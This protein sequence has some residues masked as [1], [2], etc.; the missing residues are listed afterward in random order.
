[1]RKY[2]L[3]RRRLIK[4]ETE[5]WE[6]MVEEYRELEREMCEKK[7]APTLPNVKALFLG[8]FEPLRD[9]IEKEQKM[10]RTKKHKAAFALHIDLLPADKMAEGY[11]QVVQAAIQI[12]VAIEQ[13][14]RIHSF[15]EKTKNSQSK[16]IVA[17]TEDGLHKEKQILRKRV[18]S[19][20]RKRKLKEAQKLLQKEEFKPWGRDTQAK[21]IVKN[22]GIIECDPLILMGLDKTAKH[23]LIPYVPMLKFLLVRLVIGKQQ[24]AVKNVPVKQMQKV[25]EALDMLGNTKWRVNRRVFSV[26]ESIWAR[27]GN[28]AGLVDCEDVPIPEKPSSED[29]TEIQERKWS[30]RKAKKINLERHSQRR[31]TEL[32]LSVVLRSFSHDGR[33]AFVNNHLDDIFDSADNPVNRNQWWLTDPFQFLAACINLSEALR[34]SSP[35]TVVS[36]LLIHQ[37]GWCNGLQHYTALG[38]DSME[39]AAVHLTAGDKPA[40]FY[41]EIAVRV[42]DIM[43]RDS[44]KDPATNPHALLVFQVDR[45]LVTQTVM[46]SVYGVTSV[47]AREQIKRRLE[48]KGLIT[49]D[50]LLFP[51]ACYA[52]K[53]TLAAF[54]EIFEAARGIMGWLGDCAKVDVRKQRTAFP[55]NFVHSLDGTHMM[56]TAVAC[57]DAG[58]RFAGVHNSFWTHA[59]D[60]DKMNRILR[61]KFVELYS[62]PILENVLRPSVEAQN[63]RTYA[64]VVQAS[65]GMARKLPMQLVSTAK[66]KMVVKQGLTG[67]KVGGLLVGKP[68]KLVVGGGDRRQMCINEK[69]EVAHWKERGVR[70]PC[71]TGSGLVVEVDGIGRRRVF[72][73]R[74][75]GGNQNLRWVSRT[76]KDQCKGVL[77]L[78]PNNLATHLPNNDSA[79]W[80]GPVGT[81]PSAFELGECSVTADEAFFSVGLLDE[82][83]VE[84]KTAPVD[85]RFPTTN[86][87]RLVSHATLSFTGTGQNRCGPNHAKAKP[88]RSG[89]VTKNQELNIQLKAINAELARSDSIEE[90]II[91]SNKPNPRAVVISIHI[92]IEEGTGG[93]PLSIGD[94]TFKM[95]VEGENIRA[96]LATKDSD[97]AKKVYVVG[98][99]MCSLQ[100]LVIRRKLGLVK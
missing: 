18:N 23:A 30:W 89:V 64:E 2:N 9:A 87:T 73:G 45:K 82:A 84:L 90:S 5:A 94:L 62:K 70:R 74:K 98:T 3:L 25:F 10:Q 8:W 56:M 14:V 40:D 75:K 36:H 54:G 12:G 42:H 61:E 24:D 34:S 17:D 86:Q 91:A 29:L 59:C 66:E 65:Y 49:D 57:R 96:V 51:A 83:E 97:R 88:L 78:G 100:L 32:K 16:K 60:V 80:S 72:W 22:Y 27:G 48:E 46:T 11:V 15:L 35:H 31:D 33:L 13:E 4:A 41:S 39:A 69:S 55:P 92:S 21:K 79:S 43:K 26:V 52:A 71:W 50:R 77:G 6:R 68:A 19:L 93:Q 47:G 85:F 37:D 58:L 99:S 38:R 76:E 67:T 28:I 63:L 20:I 81:S 1:M 53:V 44:N 7:L 95:K